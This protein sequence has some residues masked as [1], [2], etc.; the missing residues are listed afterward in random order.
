M[1]C[2][3]AGK[4]RGRTTIVVSGA[5][6]ACGARLGGMIRQRLH[7]QW[8]AQA[9][10]APTKL[11]SGSGLLRDGGAGACCGAEQTQG[12]WSSGAA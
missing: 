7:W 11:G 4:Q 6:G 3:A 12:N 2:R 1:E 8:A 9:A 10:V 5:Q